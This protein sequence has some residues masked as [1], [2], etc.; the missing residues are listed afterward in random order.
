ML[1]DASDQD[2]ITA[3]VTTS[4]SVDGN[5]VYMIGWGANI[6]GGS[7]VADWWIKKIAGP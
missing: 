3:L 6:V 4:G 1:D 2:Q 5:N 7:S